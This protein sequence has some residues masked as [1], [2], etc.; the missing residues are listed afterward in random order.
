MEE[1][2]ATQTKAQTKTQIDFITTKS[3]LIILLFERLFPV[4]YNYVTINTHF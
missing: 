4:G 2:T 1:K 3:L